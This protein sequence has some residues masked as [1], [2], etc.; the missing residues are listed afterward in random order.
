LNAVFPGTPLG[1]QSN[2]DI[3]NASTRLDLDDLGGE[4]ILLDWGQT[5]YPTPPVSWPNRHLEHVHL[6]DDKVTVVLHQE[7]KSTKTDSQIYHRMTKLSG[8]PLIRPLPEA[9]DIDP[10]LADI[11]DIPQVCKK[12]QEVS[13]VR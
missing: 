13:L 12:I 9:L 4:I 7:S 8:N 10:I 6:M 3:D 2:L 11:H 1:S 5:Q